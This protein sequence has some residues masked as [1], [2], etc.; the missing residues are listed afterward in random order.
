MEGLQHTLAK[1]I[2][3]KEPI[4][5]EMLEVMVRDANSSGF[6]SVSDLRLTACLLDFFVLMN[7]SVLDLVIAL[8][9]G[10]C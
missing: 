8:L 3:K 10:R 7:L 2:V 5:V 9:Q 6:L 4:T 1:P